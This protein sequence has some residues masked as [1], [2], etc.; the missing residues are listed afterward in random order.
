[1][2]LKNKYDEIFETL[3]ASRTV[4]EDE[5][6]Y[7]GSYAKDTI[8]TSDLELLSNDIKKRFAKPFEGAQAKL[9]IDISTC[10]EKINVAKIMNTLDFLLKTF[11]RFILISKKFTPTIKVSVNNSTLS[12]RV[13]SAKV[14]KKLFDVSRIQDLLVQEKKN[15]MSVS[16]SKIKA[17]V[18]FNEKREEM[19]FYSETNLMNESKLKVKNKKK[20]LHSSGRTNERS[21]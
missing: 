18:D 14:E 11:S 12:L 19:I 17:T 2:G 3:G 13:V 20:Q 7:Y 21:L 5:I 4:V 9:Q 15:F 8:A 16:G 1:M 10:V 6:V